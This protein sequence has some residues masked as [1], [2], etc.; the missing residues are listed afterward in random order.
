[1]LIPMVQAFHLDSHL[2]DSANVTVG[3]ETGTF[4]NTWVLDG[5]NWTINEIVNPVGF[6]FH[7]NITVHDLDEVPQYL[8]IYS[9]YNGNPAHI[10]EVEVMNQS[11]RNW[12]IIGN[13]DLSASMVWDNLS[14]VTLHFD[15]IYTNLVAEFRVTHTSAGNINHDLIIDFISLYTIEDD[16]PAL[17]PWDINWFTALIWLVMVAIGVFRGSKIIL[18]FAGFFGLIL[19]LLLL[20]NNSMDL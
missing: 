6:Q 18:I 1:M 16:D 17:S 20:D 12:E 8:S 11:S 7:F 15:E 19:G 14:L 2:I 13:I 9:Q 10:I 5:F 4:N 3:V